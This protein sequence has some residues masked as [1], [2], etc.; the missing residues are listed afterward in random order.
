MESVTQEQSQ[1]SM[2][3]HV[4]PGT[5]Y[6]DFV[7]HRPGVP[8]F[9]VCSAGSTVKAPRGWEKAFRQPSIPCNLELLKM[10]CKMLEIAEMNRFKVYG[11]L[12][13]VSSGSRSNIR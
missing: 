10:Y 5:T 13:H 3:E 4:C 9:G 8:G 7:S 1:Q 11:E 2:E 12:R 6:D